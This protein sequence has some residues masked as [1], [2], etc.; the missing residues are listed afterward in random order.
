MRTKLATGSVSLNKRPVIAPHQKNES[1]LSAVVI[2]YTLS[3]YTQ[4]EKKLN[5]LYIGFGMVLRDNFYISM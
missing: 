3:S 2:N 1:I 5:N 4:V